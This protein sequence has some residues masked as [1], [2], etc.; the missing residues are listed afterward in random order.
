MSQKQAHKPME[1]SKKAR[2]KPSIYGQLLFDKN[3]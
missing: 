1:Q 2:N 3:P